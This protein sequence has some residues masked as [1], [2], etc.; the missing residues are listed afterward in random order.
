MKKFVTFASQQ[1]PEKFE[2]FK[3][4]AVDNSRLRYGAT[5]YPIIPVINGYLDAGDEF[6]VLAIVAD[7]EHTRK[8]FEVLKEELKEVLEQKGIPFDEEKQLKVISIPFD[9]SIN[10]QMSLFGKLLEQ[11]N[12]WDEIYA[13]ITYGSKPAE[14]IELMMLRYIRQIKKNAYIG[15]V[16][17]GH[18]KWGKDKTEEKKA[19]IYD[20]TALVRLDDIIHTA[21][22][23][24]QQ[25]GE[26]L[27]KNLT[28]LD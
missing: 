3:Y 27:I 6:E 20:L 13:C 10:T 4:E 8:N 9:D 11:L 22:K 25:S 23:L 18:I 16:V 19:Y 7:Y 1:K 26:L 5:S 14:I 21:G 2:K 28:V 17:Y 12:D 24:N 15:C